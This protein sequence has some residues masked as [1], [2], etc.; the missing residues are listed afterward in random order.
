MSCPL[1]SLSFQG[2][3]GTT[4]PVYTKGWNVHT[5]QVCFL[6]LC[7]LEHAPVTTD[8][9]EWRSLCLQREV[10]PRY[11]ELCYWPG[12]DWDGEMGEAVAWPKNE[13]LSKAVACH[14]RAV[15]SPFL[16]LGPGWDWL[17]WPSVDVDTAP[18]CV[19]PFADLLL[20]CRIPFW[21]YCPRVQ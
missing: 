2:F 9:K 3:S 5:R 1:C 13:G 8:T 12:C 19:M 10:C 4:T 7:I 15:R 18:C 14:S 20:L 6:C 21:L 16:L 11:T 17:L